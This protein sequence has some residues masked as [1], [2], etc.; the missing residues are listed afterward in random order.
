M[1]RNDD[2]SFGMSVPLS[3]LESAGVRGDSWSGS[4]VKFT[5]KRDAGTIDFQGSFDQGRGTGDFAFAPNPEFV[6]AMQTAGRTLTTDDVLRLAIHD[7]SRSFIQSIEAQGYKDLDIDDLVKMRIHGVDADYIVAFR[8]AGYDK[9]SVEELIKT[10]IHG[11]TPT[12]VQDMKAAGF[13]KLSVEQLVKLRIHGVSPSFIK[14]MRDLGFKNL[15]TEDLVKMRIHGVSSE[16]VK[17]LR[18][19]GYNDLDVE[20]LVKMRIHGVSPQFIRQLKELGYGN[21]REERLVQFRIHGVT[22]DFIRDVRAAGFKNLTEEDLVDMSIHGRGGSEVRCPEARSRSETRGWGPR[23]RNVL[24]TEQNE[25][26]GNRRAHARS[27]C[28]AP[29]SMTTFSRRG[30][31]PWVRSIL[32]AC[33]RSLPFPRSSRRGWFPPCRRPD[34]SVTASAREL[35]LPQQNRLPT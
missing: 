22:P 29:S 13:D 24:T 33:A 20:D 28:V 30:P 12:F 4:G 14:E 10:R 3:E 6:R 27:E 35:R 17:E 16:F 34:R 5:L 19:L 8:K 32:R 15:D 1:R 31:R 21:V 7:V 9:L 18:A 2:R 26:P 11:A 25:R 23:T